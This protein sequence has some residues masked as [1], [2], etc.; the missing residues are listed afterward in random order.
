M[1]KKI[2]FICFSIFLMILYSLSLSF[3]LMKGLSTERLTKKSEMIIRGE[4]EHVQSQ[5]SKDR[6]TIFTSATIV[7]HTVVKGKVIKNKKIIVEYRGGEVEDMGMKI[8]DTVLLKKGEKVLLFLK[9]GISYQDG[10]VF[11]VVGKAQ[12]KYTIDNN[13]I[14][15][16]SGFSVAA[17]RAVIDNNIPIDELINKIKRVK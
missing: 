16:K 9:S 1:R 3:A 4:V 11:N 2:L 12:G 14:A 10:T 17:D 8:S 13:G 5:W 15:R 7:I 6:K